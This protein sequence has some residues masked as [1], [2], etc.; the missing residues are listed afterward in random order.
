MGN[1]SREPA[2][3]EPK[4]TSPAAAPDWIDDMTRQGSAALS[5]SNSTASRNPPSQRR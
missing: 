2:A 3:F 4:S 5:S 1:E